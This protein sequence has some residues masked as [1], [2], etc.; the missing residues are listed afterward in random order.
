MG[1]ALQNSKQLTYH[2]GSSQ[3]CFKSCG[4]VFH[5]ALGVDG[6]QQS[7]GSV[8]VDQ[9]GGLLAIHL[10]TI[11]NDRFVVVRSTPGKQ[12]LDKDLVVEFQKN[13]RL[14]ALLQFSEQ[15]LQCF[16]LRNIARK[17][18]EKPALALQP[19]LTDA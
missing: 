4:D 16:G 11:A 12:S 14:D 9:R 5:A 7:L 13:D 18:I 10:E 17:A 1:V 6:D 2:R 8:V 3:I 15:G 19:P